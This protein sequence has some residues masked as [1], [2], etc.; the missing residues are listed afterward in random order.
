MKPI[1]DD[2]A[3]L[4][5]G[6]VLARAFPTCALANGTTSLPL[7]RDLLAQPGIAHIPLAHLGIDSLAWLGLL[8]TLEAEWKLDL[9]NDF[10]VDDHVSAWTIGGALAR[11]ITEQTERTA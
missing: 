10:L 9:G 2:L 5:C 11:A 3:A 1:P 4:C 6:V 7:L 8:T